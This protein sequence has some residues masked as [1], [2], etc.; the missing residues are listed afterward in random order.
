ML[1]RPC[2][3]GAEAAQWAGALQQLREHVR[4]ACH[5]E[6]DSTPAKEL[7]QAKTANAGQLLASFV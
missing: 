2:E 3:T 5:S 1:T 7:P 4:A 6:G